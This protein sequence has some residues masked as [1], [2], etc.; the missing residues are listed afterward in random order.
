VAQDGT[1]TYD[2]GLAGGGAASGPP[3][4]VSNGSFTFTLWDDQD[5]SE[6]Y[7]ATVTLEEGGFTST[8]PA[9]PKL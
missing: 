2:D 6:T 7:T 3:N 1:I 9:K 4:L 5:A 8:A